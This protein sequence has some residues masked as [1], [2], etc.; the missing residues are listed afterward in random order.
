MFVDGALQPA[1]HHITVYDRWTGESIG[2]VP[3]DG[4]AEV[5]A[6]VSALAAARGAM[7]PQQRSAVLS[8]AAAL[9]ESRAEEF[10][11]LITAE[12]GV[13]RKE[14][15]R[16]V[17]RAAGNLKVAAAE[18]ER[19]RGESI[20]LPDGTRLAVTLPEPVGV[21]LGITP[22]N[23]PLNQVV[24]KAAPALAAGC[25]LLLK[26]SEKT[27]LTALA[28]A[29]LLIEAGC[30]KDMLGVVTGEPG[31]LGPLLA[32]HPDVAMVTFTGSVATGHSVAALAAGKRQLLELGGNDPLFVLPDADLPHAARL[33]A[34]GAC[35]TAG[36]SCRG[37]KRIFV[38]EEV[39]DEFTDLLSTEVAG[40]QAGDPRRSDT[41]LGPLISEEAAL[42][43]E[44]R[45]ADAV[46]DGAR[47]VTGGERDGALVHPAVLDR[48]PADTELV[49]EETFGPVAP[50]IRVR[51][52]DEAV[53]LSNSTAYGLQAGVLTRDSA[54]FWDLAARL[55]VGAVNLGE[56]PHFDSPHIPFGGVKASGIG[57][58][59]IRYAIA[60]MTVTKTV[61]LP[62][63]YGTG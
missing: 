7:T 18:A 11:A 27:P 21:V 29:E 55:R 4:A 53:R 16:E 59:G 31:E 61:T 8:R 35:A 32:S 14:T 48:V 22:F 38:W 12:S 23:R 19:I 54:R 17:S 43:V 10:S 45:I 49:R 60:E 34:G 51:G 46:R 24:V 56:G 20:P 47:L 9:L 40:K 58:E 3:R 42:V 57:R 1:R 25:P 63:P 15:L 33:A 5:S 39:A 6:A 52:A 30:A 62:G 28:F 26:P 37:I 50:V 44:R 41:D 13:C 2:S 36:Q